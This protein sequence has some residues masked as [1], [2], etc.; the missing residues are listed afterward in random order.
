MHNIA[1]RRRAPGPLDALDITAL[2]EILAFLQRS[3]VPQACISRR[4][5]LRPANQA[6]A[7]TVNL[8]INKEQIRGNQIARCV[9]AHASSTLLVLFPSPPRRSRRLIV[10]A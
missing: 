4:C 7:K 5:N 8:Y 1:G 2:Y 9:F 3:N 10:K 6:M